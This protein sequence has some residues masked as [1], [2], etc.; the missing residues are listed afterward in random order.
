MPRP[1]TAGQRHGITE[2]S[3]IEASSISPATRCALISDNP[4]SQSALPPSNRYA[5]NYTP[6]HT[7]ERAE[8]SPDSQ[9]VGREGHETRGRVLIRVSA[10]DLPLRALRGLGLFLV[11]VLALLFL[12]LEGGHVVVI[13]IILVVTT[14]EAF[15]A[16][17][18]REVEVAKVAYVGQLAIYSFSSRGQGHELM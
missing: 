5:S 8:S 17:E 6:Q 15:A 14:G 13:L 18:L 1:L 11:I 3:P 16:A 2:N 12:T 7:E 9:S 10:V 4:S